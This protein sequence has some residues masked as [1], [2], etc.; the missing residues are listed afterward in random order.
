MDLI[1]VNHLDN[2]AADSNQIYL[3]GKEDANPDGPHSG[4][5]SELAHLI[6]DRIIAL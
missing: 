6:L 1:V 5:K 4:M 3:I 2:A